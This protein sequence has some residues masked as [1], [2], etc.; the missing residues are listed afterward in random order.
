MLR[1]ISR[2]RERDGILGFAQL[3]GIKYN[4]TIIGEVFAQLRR[5]LLERAV[6][7]DGSPTCAYHLPQYVKIPA[8]YQQ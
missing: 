3:V 4:Q 7:R 1:L 2:I 5:E 8:Q 6:V